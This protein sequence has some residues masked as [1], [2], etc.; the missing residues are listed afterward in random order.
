[1]ST[2]LEINMIPHA[3]IDDTKEALVSP[4]K[5]ALVEDLYSNDGRVF[6]RPDN[7]QVI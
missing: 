6:H 3:K 4:L 2:Q 7:S 1:M 5:L